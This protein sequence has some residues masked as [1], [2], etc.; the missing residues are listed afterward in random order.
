MSFRN[1]VTIVA[2]PRPRFGK[3]L[4]ARL[5]TDFHRNENRPVVAFD[6]NS[7]ERAL[8]QF[9]PAHTVAASVQDVNGQMA[10]FDRLVTGDD[11][12]KVIDLG[13]D[14]FESFFTL[15]QQ[16]DFVEEARQRAIAVAILFVVTPD[17]TSVSAYRSL[18][19]RFGRAM[20][21]PLH[22]EVLGSAQYR[23][24]YPTSGGGALTV[25]LPVLAPG[26]RKLIDTPPFSFADSNMAS[27]TGVPL[28]AH[29]E[30]QRWL[31]RIYLE[32]RELDLRLLLADLSSSIRF[33]S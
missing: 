7:G 29:I 1:S 15:A 2:S 4:A 9:M 10:L 17:Q 24:K 25:R 16:I 26:L 22:N 27:A 12:T 32:F 31:R 8:S 6:L 20:L 18:R 30:L 14:S 13:H 5:L 19:E 21:V 23:D 11:T 3:T 28:D 33:G